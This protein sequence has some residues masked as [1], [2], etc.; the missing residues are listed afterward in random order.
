MKLPCWACC[1][2]STAFVLPGN[3]GYTNCPSS[4]LVISDLC[5]APPRRLWSVPPA[6]NPTPRSTLKNPDPPIPAGIAL[7]SNLGGMTSP[8]S[9]PQNLFA[10]ERMSLGGNAP[11]WAAWFAVALPVALTGCGLCWLL[12][13]LLYRDAEFT[14]VRQVPAVKVGGLGCS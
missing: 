1:H 6:L 14:Q 2:K 4:S 9:S 5:L 13:R 10:I 3:P 11:S 7:A 12:L 8:I